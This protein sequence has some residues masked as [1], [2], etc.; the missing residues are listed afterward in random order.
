[1]LYKYRSRT[2][3]NISDLQDTGSTVEMMHLWMTHHIISLELSASHHISI[4]YRLGE[5]S[6][7]N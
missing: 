4:S 7:E 1:M 3:M 2:I 5:N 6:P